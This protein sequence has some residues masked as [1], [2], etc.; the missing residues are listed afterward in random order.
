MTFN[1][2][3]DCPTK[4]V[5]FDIFMLLTFY[6][7]KEKEISGEK[8]VD[9]LDSLVHDDF[10]VSSVKQQQHKKMYFIKNVMTLLLIYARSECH[11]LFC[12]HFQFVGHFL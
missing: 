3:I 9:N 12:V 1:H 5:C 8:K 2:A 7:N 6:T 4:H 10:A 11:A